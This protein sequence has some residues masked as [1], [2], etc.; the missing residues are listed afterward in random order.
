MTINRITNYTSTCWSQTQH[1]Y[2]TSGSCD[3]VHSSDEDDEDKM[4]NNADCQIKVSLDNGGESTGMS[5]ADEQVKVLPVCYFICKLLN[6]MPPPWSI[7]FLFD[8]TSGATVL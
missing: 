2:C 6:L 4:E 1:S 8:P 7:S 3:T 5:G